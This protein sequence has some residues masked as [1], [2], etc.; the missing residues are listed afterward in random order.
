MRLR[1]RIRAALIPTLVAPRNGPSAAGAWP[2]APHS[3]RQRRAQGL[4]IRDRCQAGP[5]PA[6]I[7]RCHTIHL[8]ATSQQRHV[9]IVARCAD[10]QSPVR[11]IASGG[12]VDQ[13]ARIRGGAVAEYRHFLVRRE[14]MVERDQPLGKA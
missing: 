11:M 5:I 10:G 9:L 3:L 8:L 1:A 14:R 2:L 6:N 12:D 13:R 7:C 4:R